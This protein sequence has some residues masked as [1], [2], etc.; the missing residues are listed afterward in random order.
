MI[1][2]NYTL[3]LEDYYKM[4]FDYAVE[5]SPKAFRFF[6]HLP[7]LKVLV[8]DRPWNRGCAF[9]NKNYQ[10]CFNWESIRKIVAG[11]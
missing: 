7:D 10:R 11:E 6:E 9:P 5:D 1:R 8:F 4:K 2:S 3:V